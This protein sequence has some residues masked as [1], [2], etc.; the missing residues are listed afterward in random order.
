MGYHP[1]PRCAQFSV[2]GML[3]WLL[4]I[5]LWCQ[6]S[7]AF[8]SSTSGDVQALDHEGLVYLNQHTLEATPRWSSLSVMDPL[9]HAVRIANQVA[10][11]QP[12]AEHDESESSEEALSMDF[13]AL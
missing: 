3:R 10:D 6:P 5:L 9:L 1:K 8:S 12:D 4:F 7:Y 2:L 11:H 13:D